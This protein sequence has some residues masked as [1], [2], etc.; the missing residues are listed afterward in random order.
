MTV[1]LGIDVGGT[2]IAAGVVEADTGTVHERR[3][4]PTRPERGG[5]AVLDDCAGLAAELGGGTLPVGI[6][7]CELVDLAGRPTSADTVDWRD[8]DPPAA[9]ASSTTAARTNTP[10]RR[11]FTVPSR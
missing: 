2:K 5:K 7:L 1:A 11:L 8:L 4:L 9:I 10:N 6:G 3:L